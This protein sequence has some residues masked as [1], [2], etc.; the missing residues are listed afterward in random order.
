MFFYRQKCHSNTVRARHRQFKSEFR[1]FAS[2]EFVRNLNQ[3]T[4]AV[5][6]LG[7]ASASPPM[8]QIQQYLDSV[9]NDFVALF[10]AD[11]GHKT[12]PAGIV[13]LRRIV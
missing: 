3:H 2:V 9:T 11:T 6:G 4:R 13:L 12:D 1:A 7:I 8:R 5:A 10:P